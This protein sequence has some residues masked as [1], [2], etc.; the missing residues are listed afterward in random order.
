MRPNRFTMLLIFI[1]S[2][3]L[4]SFAPKPISASAS[5]LWQS[6]IAKPILVQEFR[7]PNSDWS[8][9]HRG[10]DYLVA[11]SQTVFADHDGVVSF[12]G[13]VVNRQLVSI[14]HDN[15]MVSSLEPVCSS[16]SKGEVVKTGEEL[17][18][19]CFG[20]A[21]VSHCLPKLCLHFSLRTENAYLSPLLVL[22][23][24][25][26]SRLKPWDGHFCNRLSNGQC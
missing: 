14:R 4:L 23:Q 2:A 26:P 10:V 16:K 17:G 21:Y 8:A 7:Q 24:L 20:S 5:S 1:V 25:S 22:G 13:T 18:V 15:G 9:G 12:T 3:L 19:I 6:P 11:D